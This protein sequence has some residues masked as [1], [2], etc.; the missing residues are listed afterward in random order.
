MTDLP[1]PPIPGLLKLWRHQCAGFDFAYPKPAAMLAAGMG[2]GKSAVAC[3]LMTNWQAER[4]LIVCPPSVRAV[5]RREV[6]RHCPNGRRAIILDLGSVATRTEQADAALTQ[7]GPLAIVINTEAAW[8]PPFAEWALAQHWDAVALDESH[9]GGVKN[10]G[11]Q[12][13]QFVARLTPISGHRLCL[14]GT[15]LAHHPLDAWGQYR[16]LD[17]AILG[18]DYG[19]FLARYAAPR[20]L[21]LRTRLRKSH[22]GLVAAIAECFGP[23]SP[24]LDECGEQPDWSQW[25]PGLQHADEFAARTGAVTWQ[26]KSAD[27]LDLPPLIS[28][29]REIQL[30]P[31]GQRVYDE[32]LCQL[33]AADCQRQS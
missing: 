14:T 7:R 31:E 4:V 3:A 17:P 27:V 12:A 30:G 8:R 21:K 20:Q 13:S 18:T 1:Q 28:D 6:S 32:I 11:T 9:L 24:L 2:T 22:Q 16:F 19:A 15:P 33:E 26:C 23:D 5:W 29:S 10:D 25:L